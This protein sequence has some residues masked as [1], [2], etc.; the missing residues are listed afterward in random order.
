MKKIQLFMMAMLLTLCG[1]SMT[2]AILS[3][4]GLSTDDHVTIPSTL[5][6][7]AGN[8]ITLPVS[9]ENSNANYVGFQM[10]IVLPQG[11]AP[12]TNA[13]GNIVPTKTD[14]LGDTH[15]F[16]CVY[17]AETNTIKM[18]CTSMSSETIWDTKGEL[19][20]ISLQTDANMVSGDYQLA[21]TNVLFTTSSSAPEGAK[22]Y[23]LSDATG[24]LVVAGTT[25]TPEEKTWTVIGVTELMG[26]YWNPKDTQNDMT[27]YADTDNWTL[28]KQSVTLEKGRTYEYKVAANHSL[29]ES[30]GSS[31]GG[32]ASFTV[33]ETA[34]Y[35]VV[36]LFW[37]DRKTVF[38]SV[39]KVGDIEQPAINTLSVPAQLSVEA[40]SSFSLPVSL[41][42]DNPNFVGFQ[43][44]IVLPQGVTP[45][46][47]ARG[48]I[49]P[50]K[51]DRLGDHS[52][53][54][55]FDA[56]T[57]TIKMVCTSLNS[58]TILDTKGELF[59]ISLQTDASMQSG[60]YQLTLTNVKFTTNSD[61]P[62]GAITYKLADAIGQLVVTAKQTGPDVTQLL[63]QLNDCA[64]SAER[65][66][67]SLVYDK[68]PGATQLSAMVE[69][70]RQATD[71]TDASVLQT[72]IDAFPSQIE[73]VTT[74][75]QQYQTL[76]ALLLRVETA[77]QNNE[78]ADADLVAEVSGKI[79]TARTAL[80]NGTYGLVEINNMTSQM[81][82]YYS[83]LSQVYLTLHVEQAGTM[84]NLIQ[85]KGYTVNDIK[86]LTVSGHLNDSDM[87]TMQEM[88]NLQ[89]LD[90]SETDVTKIPNN[91]FSSFSKLQSV[92][93]PKNL[94]N[95]GEYAFYSCST[96]TNPT[97]P[98]GLQT[99]NINAFGYCTSLTAIELPSTLQSLSAYSFYFCSN[100]KSITYKSMMPVAIRNNLISGGYDSKCTLYVPAIAVSTYQAATGWKEFQIVGIDVMPENILVTSQVTLEWPATVGTDSK[101]NL[102]ID[103]QE[104]QYSD[105]YGSL[106][107]NGSSTAS[108]GSFTTFWDAYNVVNYTEYNY[109]TS[110]Y[111]WKRHNY[112]SLLANTPMRADKVNVEL[113]ARTYLWDFISFPFDVKVSDIQNL[114]QNN[115]QLVI[116]RYDGQ[117]R[118]EA[119][120]SNT[121]V[122]VAADD[123]LEA[124]KGYIWQSADGDQELGYNTFL[125]PAQNNT[126]KNN[127]FTNNDVTVQLD[128]FTS[129]LSQNRSWNLIGN[130]YPSF[131]DIRA[132]QTT[133]PIT[134]WNDYNKNYQAYS[135]AEDAYILNPGQAFFIQRPLAQES[136]TF[137]KEGR[138][139]DMTIRTETN[140]NPA[141]ARAVAKTERYVYNLL[142]RGSEETLGDRT[143]IV[144]NPEAMV[145]YEAG[146]DASKFMSHESK[147]AQLFTAQGNVR[148]SINERP[149]QDGIVE[150]G[151]SIGTTGSY[152][153]ALSTKVDGEVYLI[154]RTLGTETR[155]DGTEGYTFQAVQGVSEGRFAIRFISGDATGISDVRSKMSEVRGDAYNLKGQ[156]V[157]NPTKGLYI[158]NGKKAVV[159]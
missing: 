100:L 108:L 53:S 140:F 109:N 52:F 45:V 42:N 78:G 105:I 26:S 148:F 92:V 61:A 157:A 35:N 74:M 13:R 153:I 71:Q 132:I 44:D 8:T 2:A 151:L 150:L 149:L 134:V 116:R 69:Q 63:S 49:V 121:W 95:I 141:G 94:K 19:F 9:L 129:E 156:R 119:K 104:D 113:R 6:V 137:L 131:F 122:N 72:M 117:S 90:M 103:R 20:S 76:A 133:A 18:V 120:M 81:N 85:A 83:E 66:L 41:A 145:D 32:N 3:L 24:I 138:Q 14:R 96:L 146:R 139:A 47:N 31:D 159:K 101:P 154:D 67:Q 99:I 87:Q 58:E 70:A 62:E 22:G 55:V 43:M 7:E 128:E 155:L 125:I 147:A 65:T 28:I 4:T 114:N 38:A 158:L 5:S 56:E 107:M 88:K 102:R 75:D 57:N 115:A 46:T 123:I 60:D 30:Y 77:A 15:S 54:C 91:Q 50:T 16:S 86:G 37:P 34:I 40:G 36:F 93:L 73:F 89:R 1:V 126:K 84:Y 152:T 68:V 39:Q 106:T 143:R 11:V 21:L 130:P 29:D 124:G 82:N 144:I 142:L 112:G 135:P 10:D 118:A 80:N 110:N 48:N 59:S 33:E 27:Y 98:E 79:Q 51:T 127:I 97:L 64:T 12:V 17:D 25:P 136:I 111:E 23:S